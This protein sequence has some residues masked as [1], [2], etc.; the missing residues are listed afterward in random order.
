MIAS[1]I[2]ISKSEVKVGTAADIMKG[3]RAGIIYVGD[4]RYIN[5]APQVC[6][7]SSVMASVDD[8]EVDSNL[9]VV[10]TSGSLE[11][12]ILTA[13]IISSERE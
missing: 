3:I 4:T 12:T 1:E 11:V 8:L 10:E 13:D 9:D 7:V 5:T 6:G 2:L